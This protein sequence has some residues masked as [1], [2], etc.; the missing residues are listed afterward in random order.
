MVS[1]VEVS[2]AQCDLGPKVSLSL[3]LMNLVSSSPCMHNSFSQ[4]T[5][6]LQSTSQHTIPGDTDTDP[7]MQQKKIIMHILQMRKPSSGSH[8]VNKSKKI[9][10]N[11]QKQSF[12]LF[13]WTM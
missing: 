4:S 11:K 10:Q 6:S 8:S 9:K 1:A 5:Q 12:L 3:F 2:T 7:P 13:N